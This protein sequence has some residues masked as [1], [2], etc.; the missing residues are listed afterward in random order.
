MPWYVVIGAVAVLG[1]VAFATHLLL[2]SFNKRGWVY[3]RNPDAPKGSWLG[4]IEEIYQPASA[5]VADQQAL[6]DSVRYQPES[7]DPESPGEPPA[8]D[9]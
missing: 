1:L 8:S 6:E 5:H 4:L 9:S 2:R 7:G 3:Y